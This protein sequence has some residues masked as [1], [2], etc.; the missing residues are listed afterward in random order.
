LPVNGPGKQETMA[1]DQYS[2][3]TIHSFKIIAQMERIYYEIR[4]YMLPHSINRNQLVYRSVFT[5]TS[6][7]IIIIIII[8]ITPLL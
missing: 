5:T 6:I 2:T 8:I 7:I 3:K 4:T 1:T